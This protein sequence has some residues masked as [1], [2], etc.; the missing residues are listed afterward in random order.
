MGVENS[1]KAIIKILCLY[2]GTTGVFLC[3]FFGFFY[4]KEKRHLFVQQV[5]NLREVSLEVYDILHTHKDDMPLAFKQIETNI[6]YPLR[7][8]NHKGKVIYDTLYVTLSDDEYKEGIA[9]RGDK[10]I[11]EPSMHER[12]PK[13]PPFSKK[14]EGQ[15]IDEVKPQKTYKNP[16]YQIFIQDSTLDNQI[17]FLQFKLIVY[18]LLLL[19]VIG[20]I[21]Y[22]LVRLS[23][24]PM[25][26]TI[27]SLNAFIKDSTHEINTPLSIILMSIETLRED[28]LTL[29]QKQK[30]ERIKLASKSL[31][32]LYKDLV[33]YNFPHAISDKKQHLAL[34]ELLRERLEYFTPFFE[35]KLIQVQTHIEPSMIIASVEKMSCVIDN[36]LG[37]AIKYNKKGGKIDI[38]LAQGYLSITD[39]GCGM[40][41]EERKKIFDRYVRCNDFQGGFGIGLTLIKRICDEYH[42][43]IEVQSQIGQGSSFILSWNA[44][45]TLK[46]A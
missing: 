44:K 30:I 10:V 23:L 3:V 25:Q 40:S 13:S 16:R 9:Y 29:A 45:P 37:N 5:S 26:E 42:I 33:A 4:A 8:Y 17:L 46:E 14:Q 18:F 20:V 12:F 27:N 41:I 38:K 1:K 11:I 15:Q 21:A 22:F 24:K 32:H 43:H 31:N 19:F 28:N 36:L 6:A 35:Q 39:S 34:H 7:I 2:L